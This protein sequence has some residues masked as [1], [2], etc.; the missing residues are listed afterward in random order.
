MPSI[1]DLLSNPASSCFY[2][3]RRFYYAIG[4]TPSVDLTE[5]CQVPRHAKFLLLGCGDIRNILRTVH[6]L[7]QLKPQPNSLTFHLNDIDDVLL[8]RNAVLLQII[9]ILDPSKREDVEFLWNVWYNLHLSEDDFQRLK[10]ILSHILDSTLVSF[11]SESDECSTAIKTVVKFWL[12]IKMDVKEAQSQRERFI[13]KK[14]EAKLNDE[15][16][17][18][19]AVASLAFSAGFPHRPLNTHDSEEVTTYFRSGST[20]VDSTEYT[21]PTFFCPHV[22]GW[23]VHPASLPYHAFGS[24]TYM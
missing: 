6:E 10:S 1:E 5:G 11:T 13:C 14:L 24:L 21:N 18:S 23:R 8:A 22:S 7:S 12:E 19:D 16:T 2:L 4:N 20:D 17:F 9:H 15:L 3:N